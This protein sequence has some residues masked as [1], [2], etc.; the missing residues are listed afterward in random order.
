MKNVF[1]QILATPTILKDDLLVELSL[2]QKHGI[3]T[4]IPLS[5]Y[6]SSI[7]AQPKPNGQLKILVD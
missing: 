3:T 6:S 7:Y 2:K 5:N 1:L 4:T